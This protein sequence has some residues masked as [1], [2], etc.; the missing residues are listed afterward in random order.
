MSATVPQGTRRAM[1]LS[2]QCINSTSNSSLLRDP[3]PCSPRQW[4]IRCMDL[5]SHFRLPTPI[6]RL[7][8]AILPI[9]FNTLAPTCPKMRRKIWSSSQHCPR[10]HPRCL[11]HPFQPPQNSKKPSMFFA[12]QPMCPNHKKMLPKPFQDLPSWAETGHL[13]AILAQLGAI[14]AHLG[15]NLP[16]TS[17][18]L[19]P[20][21]PQLRQKFPENR[22]MNPKKCPKTLQD[23]AKPPFSSISDPPSHHFHRFSTPPGLIF[24]HQFLQCSSTSAHQ[25]L[26][27]TNAPT[28]Q[29]HYQNNTSP[30]PIFP[31]IP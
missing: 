13:G 6:L 14:M 28:I 26:H 27:P 7:L 30:S 1:R 12:I 19:R 9:L 22:L 5:E 31:S 23:P 16:P 20:S 29:A 25:A 11:N 4:N 3:A 18:I 15:R 8:V 17:P 2:F 24:G 10:H 21:S